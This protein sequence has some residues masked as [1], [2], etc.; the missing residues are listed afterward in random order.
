MP[1]VFSGFARA[2]ATAA[3]GPHSVISGELEQEGGSQN[4][5]G[6]FFSSSAGRPFLGSNAVT[7][8]DIQVDGSD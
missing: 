6:R 5:R 1:G 4:G 2:D 7:D 3:A 8:S